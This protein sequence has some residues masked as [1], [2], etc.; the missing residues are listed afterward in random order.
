MDRSN[1]LMKR[2]FGRCDRA[3]AIRNPAL[4]RRDEMLV[5]SAALLTVF[6]ALFTVLAGCAKAPAARVAA[7]PAPQAPLTP[8]TPEQVAKNVETFDF[9][10]TTIQEK[11]FDPNLNG[12]DW[13]AA[14]AELRPKV[15]SAT[16]MADA[17]SAMG[18][19]IARLKQTHFGVIPADAYDPPTHSEI[20][21]KPDSSASKQDP[22]ASKQASS[23][24]EGSA[25]RANAS[26]PPATPSRDRAGYAGF[27]VRAVDGKV[28]ITR[29]APGSAADL[30]GLKLGWEIVSVGPRKVRPV[31][32]RTNGMPELEGLPPAV[33][34][35][36]V[37]ARLVRASPGEKL[38]LGLLD[39][40][41]RAQVVSLTV[42]PPE[43]VPVVFGNLPTEHLVLRREMLPGN[44]GYI[45]I[46]IWLDPTR[47]AKFIEESAREFAN[48]SGVI[49]D[50]RG[51]PGGL[52]ALAMT[53]ASFFVD[54]RN[55]ELGTLITRTF[56]QRFVLNPRPGLYRGPVAVLV[57]EL[58]MSTSEIFASGM[59][60]LGR[61]RVFGVKTPGAALPSV[62]V[63]LPNGDR[64]QYAY[65]NYLSFSGRAL[66]GTGVTPDEVVPL[67]RQSLLTGRDPVIAAASR[68]LT[69][70]GYQPSPT[71]AVP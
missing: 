16:S 50:L 2:L 56:R 61:A 4:K 23:A 57:D 44:I 40:N 39:A 65:A 3:C 60:D 58:S 11:H 35:T 66:E 32:A 31:L 63:N 28:L 14:K 22:S 15:E 34:Q 26:P 10:W 1:G 13:P 59:Q 62:I 47:T 55:R 49:I 24:A 69:G 6:L 30:A 48:A 43:G 29:V 37:A 70:H 27:D 12:A 52:G 64:L 5:L 53:A 51:N 54:D 33:V 18:E 45:H 25:K 71:S 9:I 67:T 42:G 19:L 38:H 46:N 7:A 68:W 21:S 17:R 41:E 20:E 8:L 36:M